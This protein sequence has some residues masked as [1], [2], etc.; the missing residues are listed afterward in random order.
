MDIKLGATGRTVTGSIWDSNPKSVEQALR[1]YD[2]QLY[3]R[4]RPDKS[5][6][7]GCWEIRRRPATKSAV[8]QGEHEGSPLYTLE[9]VENDFSSNIMFTQVLH[10]GLVA[11]I[12]SIDTWND[13]YW[14]DNLDYKGERAREAQRAKQRAEMIYAMKQQK[15][16]F[17]DLREAILSGTNPAQLAAAWGEISKQ[18]LK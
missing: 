8:Y 13:K 2:S 11:Y 1:D 18:S 10:Y 14:A 16:A 15:S 17:K 7:Y 5:A 4:W 6:G 12:K 3:V 9:Y